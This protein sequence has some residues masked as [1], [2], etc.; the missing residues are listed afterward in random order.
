MTIC[1]FCLI[2]F[3]FIY[4]SKDVDEDDEED[5]DDNS[6]EDDDD[7][8]EEDDDDDDDGDGLLA[9]SKYDNLCLIYTHIYIQTHTKICIS[10]SLKYSIKF[11]RDGWWGS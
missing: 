5:D 7:N 2:S 11:D 10:E 6:E 4:W 9:K 3:S 8:D 1:I